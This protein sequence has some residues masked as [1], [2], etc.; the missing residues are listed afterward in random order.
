[1]ESNEYGVDTLVE[2]YVALRDEKRELERNVALKVEELDKEMQ[3][4]T[5]AMNDL[6]KEL[7]AD[8]I[9]TNYGTVI[10]TVKTKYWTN[11]WS[12]FHRFMKDNDAFELLEKRIHQTNMKTFMEENPDLHPE[13]LNMDKEY[14]ITI[15]KKS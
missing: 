10:R 8:S 1:M 11:D 7:G 15:R 9:R 5:T 12:A 2:A 14:A 13:G 4:L 6:C 3:V